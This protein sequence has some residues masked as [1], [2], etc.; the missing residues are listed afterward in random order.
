MHIRKGDQIKIMAGADRGKIGKVLG[1]FPA[2][3]RIVAEGINIKRKHLRPRK[4]GQKGEL[5]EMPAAFPVSRASLVCSTCGKPVRIA[6]K[7]EGARK[8]RVCK[9]CGSVT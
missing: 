2:E 3:G 6:R 9:K 5:V 8:H 1:A 7:R 4:Q